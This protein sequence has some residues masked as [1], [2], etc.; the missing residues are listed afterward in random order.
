MTQ[1]RS[2]DGK[3]LNTLFLVLTPLGPKV[4]TETPPR[5]S[6]VGN[7]GSSGLMPSDVK[8]GMSMWPL[9]VFE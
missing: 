2:E 6:P 9:F 8:R 3:G 1:R 7:R 5:S 4:M